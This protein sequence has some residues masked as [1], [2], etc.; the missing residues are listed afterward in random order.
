[1]TSIKIPSRYALGFGLCTL[2]FVIIYGLGLARGA[3]P[4]NTDP[5]QLA[6][7]YHDT[8]AALIADEAEI[9]KVEK[10]LTIRATEDANLF[11]YE[12]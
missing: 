3:D 2:A 12:Q 7:T 4:Q 5:R 9:W 10:F 11:Y 8:Y 1:M 6:G